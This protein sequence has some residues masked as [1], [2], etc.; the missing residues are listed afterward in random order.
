MDR[1]TARSRMSNRMIK[2]IRGM[3]SLPTRK[4]GRINT[5]KREIVI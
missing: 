5:K 4:K 3:I 2:V 1:I